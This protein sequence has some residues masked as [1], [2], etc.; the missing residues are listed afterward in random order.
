MSIG[1]GN[2]LP[3][4][5]GGGPSL[6]EQAYLNLKQMV[7]IGG[8][9]ADG[10][11]EAE[12]RFARAR[13]IAASFA[14]ER[15]SNQMIALLCTDFIPLWES[16]L[17]LTPGVNDNDVDRRNLIVDRITR[18]VNASVD[19]LD[20]ELQKIDERFSVHCL[21]PDPDDP[22]A[23]WNDEITTVPGRTFEDWD[24][25]DPDACGPA[26][27]G[28]RYSTIWPNY[29]SKRVVKVIFDIDQGTMTAAQKVL[30]G[31]AEAV[32]TEI[33]PAVCGLQIST[34]VDSGAGGFILDIS[35]LDIGAFNA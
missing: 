17:G 13:G 24:P 23:V 28:G 29:S 18:A 19:G 33:L 16:I 21:E 1:G 6:T 22:R 12:W 34:S 30:V 2:P 5:V 15:A 32:L 3:F 8:S 26:F 14:D 20:T 31:R 11:I 4:Q 10:T 7:G 9:A 35:L 27:G 25:N